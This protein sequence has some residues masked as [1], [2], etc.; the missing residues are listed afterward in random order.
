MIWF[1]FTSMLF[2]LALGFF[3]RAWVIVPV[4]AGIVS[5]GIISCFI[6][7]TQFENCAIAIVGCS[8]ALQAGF[9][10]SASIFG[11]GKR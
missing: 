6:K 7:E 2:G 3:A 9:L 4:V 10:V 1:I 11:W 5:V 8:V